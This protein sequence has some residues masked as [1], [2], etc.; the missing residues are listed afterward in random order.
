MNGTDTDTSDVSLE[1]AMTTFET[2]C[3]KAFKA[4]H[5]H[6]FLSDCPEAGR[7]P[8]GLWIQNK[9]V[10]LMNTPSTTDTQKKLAEIHTLTKRGIC[11]ALIE[12]YANVKR[13]CEEAGDET[14]KKYPGKTTTQRTGS[15]DAL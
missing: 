8:K 4:V 12:Y 15:N 11:K 10:H 13:E 7:I 9:E 3:I 1:E 5:H 6:T 2:I 14:D